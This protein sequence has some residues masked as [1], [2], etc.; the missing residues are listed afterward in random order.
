M[1]GSHSQPEAKVQIRTPVKHLRQSTVANHS[2]EKAKRRA[3]HLRTIGHSVDE[4][5][6]LFQAGKLPEDGRHHAY[7][8]LD[9]QINIMHLSQST[10]QTSLFIIFSLATNAFAVHLQ[11]QIRHKILYVLRLNQRN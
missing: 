8:H 4:A 7:C 2:G 1:N 9:Q 3:K 10:Q 11:N 6:R 5:S